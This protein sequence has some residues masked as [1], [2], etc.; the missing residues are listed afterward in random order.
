MRKFLLSRDFSSLRIDMTILKDIT[1]ETNCNYVKESRAL[2]K[3]HT[4]NE[5]RLTS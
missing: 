4:I 5:S 3:A 2:R 1:L